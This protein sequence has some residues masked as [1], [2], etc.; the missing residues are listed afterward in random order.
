MPKNK[1]PK[2]PPEIE[3]GVVQLM[4]MDY[5]RSAI[6]E[7]I[8]AQF[9]YDLSST[10]VFYIANR[11]VEIIEALKSS[12][13]QPPA[14]A[15]GILQDTYQLIK[16]RINSYKR[17]LNKLEVLEL[18]LEAGKITFTEF[19][20][21]KRQLNAPS[22]SELVAASREMFAQSSP[23]VPPSAKK[24]KPQLPIMDEDTAK[25]L[26]EIH[27]LTIKKGDTLTLERELPLPDGQA[28]TPEDNKKED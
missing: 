5:E 17:S 6:R 12:D 22:L 21:Q 9:D 1:V 18:R 2:I 27:R 4:G 24:D 20:K 14:E 3:N 16:R 13:V 10:N 8:K 15:W 23:K 25:R 28:S 26:G 7:I 11:N 19:M